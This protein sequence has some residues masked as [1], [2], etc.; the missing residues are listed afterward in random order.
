MPL[1]LPNLDDRRWENLVEEARALIPRYA[2]EWTD[3][4]THDPGITLIELF[5][6][7]VEQDMYRLNRVPNRYRHGFLAL[8]GETPLPPRPAHTTLTFT[9][10]DGMGGQNLPAGVIVASRSAPRMYFRTLAA[11]TVTEAQIS[12][13]QVDDGSTSI[14]QT[15]SWREGLPF[16]PFGTRWSQGQSA[17]YL[18]FDQPLEGKEISLWLD[19]EGAFSSHLARHLMNDEAREIEETCRQQRRP[20]NCPPTDVAADMPVGFPEH[21]SVRLAWEYYD[22]AGWK[23]LNV[24]AGEVRDET[25]GFTLDGNVHLKPPHPIAKSAVGSLAEQHY[26]LRCRV[27]SGTPDVLPI[28]SSIRLNTVEVEQSVPTLQSFVIGKGVIAPVGK[29][30]KSGQINQLR[31]RVKANDEITA[32]EAGDMPEWIETF[33]A[34]YQPATTQTRGIIVLACVS[35]GPGH[36]TPNEYLSLPNAPIDKGQVQVWTAANSFTRWHQ[37]F[38]LDASGTEDADFVLDATEG[39]ITFGDG[40][41]GRVSPVGANVFVAYGMT[42]GSKGSVSARDDWDLAITDS[43]GTY[44]SALLKEDAA[45]VAAKFQGIAG[46][47]TND[48]ADQ[49]N[50]DEAAGRAIEKLWVH[51]RLIDLCEQAQKSTL[52]QIERDNVLNV[53]APERANTLLDFE[54]VTLDIPGTSIAR[55]RAWAG[56]D[57]NYPCISTPGTVTVVVVPYF[58]PDAPQASAGLLKHVRQYLNRRKVVGTRLVVAGAAYREV[59]VNVTVRSKHGAN[60]AQMRDMIGAALRAFLHPLTGGPDQRGWPFGRDVYRSEI[61]EQVALV[62]GVDYVVSLELIS[63]EA[64]CNNVCLGPTELVISGKHQVNVVTG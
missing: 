25:R 11:L 51:E 35:I 29:E 18:G 42:A 8:L 16:A 22:G 15:R 4:N 30:P 21:H 26:Y 1:T 57:P 59:A 53:R 38:D 2:P 64:T 43:L 28:I 24:A 37:R 31:L 7:L 61:L 55:A 60:A 49:E 6:W 40:E 34:K 13:V 20:T 17:L 52:D 9:L 23:R 33:V 39:T 46:G 48:G 44:N 45:G 63:G 14:D 58:P 12:A 41:R 50:L 3:H 56:I 5:A 19:F 62:A 27:E 36:G 32:L 10:H 54:R 47:A